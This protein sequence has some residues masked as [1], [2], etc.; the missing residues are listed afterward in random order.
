[1]PAPINLSGSRFGRLEAIAVEYRD[2]IRRWRC[3]CDCGAET[4]AR[5]AKLRNGHTSSCGCL[6]RETIAKTSRRHG[7]AS[8][9]AR[10]AEYRIWRAMIER[11]TNAKHKSYDRYGGRGISVCPEWRDSFEAFFAYMGLRPT[12][13]HSI[14]RFPDNDGDYRPGNVRWALP[15]EQG[16]NRTH[17]GYSM[18]LSGITGRRFGKLVVVEEL[19][20]VPGNGVPRI[21]RWRCDCETTG[22]VR[23]SELTRRRKPKIGCRACV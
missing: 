12:A 21:V 13:S 23:L 19:A 14:D 9:S 6:A 16:A 18:A 20:R 5:T 3:R 1:M 2:G 15:T 8:R 11:C 22:Q 7:Q 10:T 17:R 4:V